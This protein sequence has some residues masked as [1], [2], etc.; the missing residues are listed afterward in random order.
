MANLDWRPWEGQAARPPPIPAAAGIPSA[1]DARDENLDE[2]AI[3]NAGPVRAVAIAAM[4]AFGLKLSGG[5]PCGQLAAFAA[6][7]AG[8]AELARP[9][10]QQISPFGFQ[11]ARIVGQL[12]GKAIVH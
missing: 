9:A 6:S 5:I 8:E 3:L 11:T 1:E 12:L 10:D 2:D 4:D 7:A